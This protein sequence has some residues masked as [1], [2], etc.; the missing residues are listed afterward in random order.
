MRN[1]RTSLIALM[2]ALSLATAPGYAFMIDRSAWISTFGSVIHLGAPI[3][4]EITERAI[5]QVTPSANPRMIQ[6]IK[7]GNQNTDFTHQFD[8]QY[9][10]DSSTVGNGG[11]RVG[12]N[13]IQ[14]DLREAAEAARNNPLFFNPIHVRFRDIV[15]DVVATFLALSQNEKCNLEESACPARTLAAEAMAIQA[16]GVAF[17]ENPNP[18]PDRTFASLIGE[19]NAKVNSAL[20]RHCRAGNVFS[21]SRCFDQLEDMIKDNRDFQDKAKY[22]R[23][24]QR[25]I[26]AYKAWQHLGHA[27]HTT[28]DFFA[29][30]NYVELMSGLHGPHCWL[31]SNVPPKTPRTGFVSGAKP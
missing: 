5:G 22:L 26:Q 14:E 18:D 2:T 17:I 28:Q 21:G 31:K 13:R 11:F 8:A 7:I 16:E 12:F 3:H 19:V 27:F 10:F 25:E 29:H 9:H 1:A 23:T 30:S 6:N 15:E 4:E 24:L 20:G